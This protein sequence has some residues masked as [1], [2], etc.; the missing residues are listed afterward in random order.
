MAL[1]DRVVLSKRNSKGE[2]DGPEQGYGSWAGLESPDELGAGLDAWFGAGSR[3]AG[4]R[5]GDG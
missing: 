3:A 2:T 5:G 4:A 1:P